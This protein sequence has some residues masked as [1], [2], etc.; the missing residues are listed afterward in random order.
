MKDLHFVGRKFNLMWSG[1]GRASVPPGGDLV[2]PAWAGWGGAWGEQRGPHPG[3]LLP[4]Q[5]PVPQDGQH[6]SAR[7]AAERGDGGFSPCRF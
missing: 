3:T 4:E 2:Q 1:A 6:V 5:P 7:R